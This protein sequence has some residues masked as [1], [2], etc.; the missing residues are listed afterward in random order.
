MKLKSEGTQNSNKTASQH[1]ENSANV[2]EVLL[3]T[4]SFSIY[5]ECPNR[6]PPKPDDWKEIHSLLSQKHHCS[7]CWCPCQ[8]TQEDFMSVCTPFLWVMPTQLI[9]TLSLIYLFS[10]TCC[11]YLPDPLKYLLFWTQDKSFLPACF[12]V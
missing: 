7:H 5:G 12:N 4:I 11:I 10:L 1:Y 3:S 9:M 8:E 2:E 6:D